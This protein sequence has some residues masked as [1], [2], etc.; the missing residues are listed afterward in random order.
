M[1]T[2]SIDPTSSLGL[3]VSQNK[4]T[5]CLY[6]AWAHLSF[7]RNMLD[8]ALDLTLVSVD[9]SPGHDLWSHFLRLIYN[10]LVNTIRTSRVAKL[11]HLPTRIC[12]RSSVSTIQHHIVIMVWILHGNGVIAESRYGIS[13][14][15]YVYFK[16]S[17]MGCSRKHLSVVKLNFPLRQLP[18]LVGVF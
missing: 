11:W 13:V 6:Q 2:D 15:L 16:L 4:N 9:L 1:D 10:R 17:R 14:P 12:I 3:G 18:W 8:W 5:L 7:W